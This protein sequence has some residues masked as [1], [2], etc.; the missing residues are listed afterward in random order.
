MGV[1][2]ATLLFRPLILDPNG[3]PAEE[4]VAAAEEEDCVVVDE[5]KNKR[6]KTP[7]DARIIFSRVT[8][9][10]LGPTPPSLADT[11]ADS[12]SRDDCNGIPLSQQSE[13]FKSP[14]P[15]NIG[16]V[17]DLPAGRRQVSYFLYI[18]NFEECPNL[19]E[20]YK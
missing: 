4:R 9:I 12:L 11:D 3:V 1:F 8:G 14:L 18:C 5:V 19:Y 17:L 15:N 13:T 16:R 2:Q 20:K 10:H 6:S 7:P